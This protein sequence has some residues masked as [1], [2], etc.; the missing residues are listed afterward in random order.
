MEAAFQRIRDLSAGKAIHKTPSHRMLELLP[1]KLATA[2]VYVDR[3]DRNVVFLNFAEE[4][5][6]MDATA[7]P[8]LHKK[9]VT[10]F[11]QYGYRCL[12]VKHSYKCIVMYPDSN[13]VLF[14]DSLDSLYPQE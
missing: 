8:Q 5:V 10:L 12:L 13:K 9:V 7:Y 1:G 2:N 4:G 11:E 3:E 6:Y 14:V